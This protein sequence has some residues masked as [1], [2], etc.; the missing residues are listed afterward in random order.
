MVKPKTLLINK[1]FILLTLGFLYFSTWAQN[2]AIQDSLPFDAVIQEERQGLL[3]KFYGNTRFTLNQAY[4]SNWITGGESSITTLFALDY[5]LNLSNRRGLVWDNNVLLSLGSTYIS[6]DKFVKKADDRFEINSLVGKQINQ[7]WNYSAFFNLKTQMLP[8]YRYYSQ[9]GEALR[10]RISRIFSPA[11][12]QGGVGW[13]LKKEQK[14]WANLAPLTARILFVSKLFTKDL[15]SNEKYFGVDAGTNN[16]FFFG[17]S[18][19]GFFKTEIMTNITLENKFNFYINYLEKIQNIDVDLNTNIRLK[20]NDW[21][22]MNFVIHMLYDDDLIQRLQL[23]EL[24]GVGFN[25]DL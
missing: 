18:F 13:Y 24:F 16:K 19:S 7:H 14:L 25:M 21:I 11:Y 4:F 3:T 12:A 15:E 8:G 10:E 22:S 5:N 23:R 20:V 2:Q 1:Y 6:G 9:V 17:A